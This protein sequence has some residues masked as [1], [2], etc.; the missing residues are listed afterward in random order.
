VTSP[1]GAFAES[2]LASLGWPL[3]VDD[4]SDPVADWAASGAMA[5]TG[6]AQGPPLVCTGPAVVLRGALLAL[7]QLAG[8]T[9]LPGLG[10][11]GERAAIL[12]LRR[13]GSRS[14]G[15]GARLLPASDGQVCVALAREEDRDRFPALV[16]SADV[17]DPW[18]AVAAWARGTPAA[19]VRDRGAL[20][21]LPVSVVG[22]VTAELPWQLDVAHD[23]KPVATTPVVVDLSSMWAGPLCSSLLRALGCRVVK[24]EDPRR[25]DGARRGPAELFDL[26]NAGAT[27]VAVDLGSEEGV[28]RLRE[29]LLR[30][31]VVIEGSR[32]RALRH[33]GLGAEDLVERSERLTWVSITG[34]GREEDRVA[35]GDDAAAAG[36]LVVDGCFVG[37]AVADPLTG[38]HAGLAAWAG[39]RRGGSCLVS[40]PLAR[41][42]A[43]AA[44]SA[45][46]SGRVERRHG[47]W[48]VEAASGWVDVRDPLARKA[49]GRGPSPP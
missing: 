44:R 29:L 45:D 36:G 28:D 40:V 41:V 3:R 11:L 4:D 14:C 48:R 49:V 24:V 21:G 38:V 19:Q 22:E 32:A 42:A 39:I 47:A 20:L 23:G 2:L 31:D 15:G 18:E 35:F 13:A 10:L 16:E 5:L 7:R 17:V 26:L 37:D 25:P 27:A 43:T 8:G 1:A 12:G 30:A 46:T 34:Y 9:A 6:R 33:L